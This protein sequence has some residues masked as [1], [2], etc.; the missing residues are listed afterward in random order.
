M[1]SLWASF[2]ERDVEA[3]AGTLVLPSYLAHLSLGP[4]R[5]ADQAANRDGR[6]PLMLTYHGEGRLEEYRLDPREHALA[7]I[8]FAAAGINPAR[9]QLPQDDAAWHWGAGD[10][11]REAVRV[12]FAPTVRALGATLG[13]PIGQEGYVSVSRRQVWAGRPVVEAYVKA[14]LERLGIDAKG[15]EFEFATPSSGIEFVA[16][17]VGGQMLVDDR[18]TIED[19]LRFAG[20]DQVVA[21]VHEFVALDL[22]SPAEDGSGVFEDGVYLRLIGRGKAEESRARQPLAGQPD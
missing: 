20:L 3:Y 7:M 5:L 11:P 15:A 22:G 16:G 12:Y 21:Q 17:L 8:R 13:R 9:V 6:E 14:W 4:F 1:I 2:R 19:L 10:E 18:M